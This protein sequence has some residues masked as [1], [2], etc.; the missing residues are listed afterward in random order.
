M[1]HLVIAVDGELYLK[2]KFRKQEQLNNLSGFSITI[3]KA[4]KLRLRM[5]SVDHFNIGNVECDTIETY[6]NPDCSCTC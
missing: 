6:S 1:T 3:S 2:F 5:I 4:N